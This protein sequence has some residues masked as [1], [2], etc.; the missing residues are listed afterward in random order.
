MNIVTISS[1]QEKRNIANNHSTRGVSMESKILSDLV[2]IKCVIVLCGIMEYDAVILEIDS[3]WIKIKYRKN[4]KVRV[5]NQKFISSIRLTD[6]E[7]KQK[8]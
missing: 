4:E 6:S 8:I 3:Q 7:Q 2:G 5:L 1:A